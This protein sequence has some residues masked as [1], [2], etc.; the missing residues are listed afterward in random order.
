M[1]LH[2]PDDIIS[3]VYVPVGN[4]V[5]LRYIFPF[6]G[7]GGNFSFEYS[8]QSKLI[9][10]TSLSTQLERFAKG[11]SI[12]TQLVHRNIE[13]N[14]I[15]FWMFDN[16]VSQVLLCTPSISFGKHSIIGNRTFFNQIT[17]S[18]QSVQFVLPY[19]YIIMLESPYIIETKSYDKYQTTKDINLIDLSDEE[20]LL[21][22]RNIDESW[23][24]ILLYGLS[25]FLVRILHIYMIK[26][27]YI[28]CTVVLRYVFRFPDKICSNSYKSSLG[29]INDNPTENYKGKTDILIISEETDHEFMKKISTCLEKD[30]YKICVPARDFDAGTSTFELYFTA[31]KDTVSIIVICSKDFIN[32]PFLHNIVFNDFILGIS[33]YG[34]MQNN[35]ILLIRSFDCIIP[36]VLGNKYIIINAEEDPTEEKDTLRKICKWADTIFPWYFR[37]T[38]LFMLHFRLLMAIIVLCLCIWIFTFVFFA[39]DI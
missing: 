25:I 9:G 27:H 30:Q 24:L 12:I 36:R 15:K 19:T 20:K 3:Y 7:S 6:E 5:L 37:I 22:I 35:K 21:Y 10:E 32:D 16:H 23:N 34:A 17:Q 26:I 33:E 39:D 11:C 4:I 13:I 14:Q 2:Q 31:I 8:I 1:F 18:K 28:L 38:K 29:N